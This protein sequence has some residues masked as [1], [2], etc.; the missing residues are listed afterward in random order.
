M[1]QDV[2]PGAT[3]FELSSEVQI[4]LTPNLEDS[5]SLSPLFREPIHYLDTK[6]VSSMNG[7]TYQV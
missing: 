1:F 4:T 6:D 5:T 7:K 2:A 3:E